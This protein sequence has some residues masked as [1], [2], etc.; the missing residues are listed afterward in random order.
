MGVVARIFAIALAMVCLF[1]ITN[2]SAGK[3]DERILRHLVPRPLPDSPRP[4]F[5]KRTHILSHSL[6]TLG[7]GVDADTFLLRTLFGAL[8]VATVTTVTTLVWPLG[9]DALLEGLILAGIVFAIPIWYVIEMADRYRRALRR[10]LS[11][12]LSVMAAEV[13]RGKSLTATVMTITDRTPRTWTPILQ[14]LSERLSR[15]ED[16]GA[17]LLALDERL[18]DPQIH[19]TFTL[20][21]RSWHNHSA[22]T[23]LDNLVERSLERSH[24]LVIARSEKN[25]QL[26][27]IPVAI[28]TLVPGMIVLFVPLL[29]SLKTLIGA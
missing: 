3:S 5:P 6:E 2:L 11:A 16:F 13:R 18:C 1:G 25:Q 19:T 21:A 22:P 10:D 4:T 24:H 17:T 12:L 23:L 14:E 27:W 26:I 9:L 29:F 20:L 8:S 7:A 15:G 28:A